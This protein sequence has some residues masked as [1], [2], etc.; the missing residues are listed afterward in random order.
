[1]RAIAV[2]LVLGLALGGVMILWSEGTAD[3]TAVR[4][5]AA[6]PACAAGGGR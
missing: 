1:M 4:V 5:V 2:S 6:L 3:A